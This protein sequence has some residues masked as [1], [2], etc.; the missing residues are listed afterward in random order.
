MHNLCTKKHSH[1]Q[2]MEIHSWTISVYCQ[3]LKDVWSVCKTTIQ[4]FTNVFWHLFSLFFCFF[5]V[6]STLDHHAPDCQRIV[7]IPNSKLAFFAS[8]CWIYYVCHVTPDTWLYDGMLV[9]TIN[10]FVSFPFYLIHYSH[11]VYW[12][13]VCGMSISPQ[14]WHH[15]N[16]YSRCSSN[17]RLKQK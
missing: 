17:Q 2:T 13:L 5:D 7:G 3:K 9:F 14:S 12:F 16:Q 10:G 6:F 1:K 4:W 15:V 8:N 11:C